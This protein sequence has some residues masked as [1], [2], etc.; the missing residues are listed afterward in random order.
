MRR[1]K[2]QI[3][4]IIARDP[5]ARSHLEVLLC[6][7]SVHVLVIYRVSH[8]FWQYKLF[9]MAR[10][11]SG[12]GRFLTGIEIHPGAQIGEGLFIDHGMG[13]V[14]GETAEIG[15]NV[16]LY[17]GVTL[18]GVLPAANSDDQRQ[19]KRHPTIHDNVIIGSGA[20]ILGPITIGNNAR[21]G[22]NAVVTRDVAPGTTV[23]GIPAKPFKQFRQ[24]N[25]IPFLPNSMPIDGMKSDHLASQIEKMRSEITEL[26]T[27]LFILE[28]QTSPSEEAQPKKRDEGC[29]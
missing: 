10:M 12:F 25:V 2:Q 16:T 15:N 4:T 17:P 21:I 22:S 5:S 19:K 23:V 18:G 6:Y 11:I 8:W 28:G 3:D 1:F 14:I 27:R 26:R 29:A 24:Q 13:V 7:P 9:L 20:Q